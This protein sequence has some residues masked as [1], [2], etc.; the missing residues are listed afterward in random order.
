[1]RRTHFYYLFLLLAVGIAAVWYLLEQEPYHIDLTNPYPV[2]PVPSEDEFARIRSAA[3]A[4]DAESQMYMG[5]F[6]VNGDQV[7]QDFAKAAEWYRKAAEQGNARAQYYLGFLYELGIGVER[8]YKESFNLYRAAA[9]QSDAAAHMGIA[10][11]YFSFRK[12]MMPFDFG[13]Y[14]LWRL[15]AILLSDITEKAEFYEEAIWKCY[16]KGSKFYQNDNALAKMVAHGIEDDCFKQFDLAKMMFHGQGVYLD[17]RSGR[18]WL[19]RSAKN[20]NHTAAFIIGMIDKRNEVIK[21]NFDETDREKFRQYAATYEEELYYRCA[22]AS[23]NYYADL[24]NIKRDRIQALIKYLDELNDLALKGHVESQFELGVRLKN[25]EATQA[26]STMWLEK[27]AQAGHGEAMV[28]LGVDML[29]SNKSGDEFVGL[30]LLRE[31]NDTGDSDMIDIAVGKFK[32]KIDPDACKALCEWLSQQYQQGDGIA[33]FYLGAIYE[34]MINDEKKATEWYVKSYYANRFESYS[35]IIKIGEKEAEKRDELFHITKELYPHSGIFF[36]K[37]KFYSSY[38]S[39][40]Y[41]FVV[42]AAYAGYSPAVIQILINIYSFDYYL[43]PK[44]KLNRYYQSWL[45]R[46]FNNSE[47]HKMKNASSNGISFM[48]IMGKRMNDK[49]YIEDANHMTL[50]KTE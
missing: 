11:F 3:E 29:L 46:W 14:E 7:K 1:M 49:N 21:G 34:N 17:R 30:Q 42:P 6:H 36:E 39:I 18:S 16:N 25:D 45:H 2:S 19:Y 20:G 27:A 33:A 38:N 8:N 43:L 22:I 50:Y 37:K 47:K 41:A 32:R 9:K 28:E 23:R 48:Y 5:V 10:G 26:E 40:E 13:D 35:K 44:R 15:K 4:G 24:R 31:V 12:S